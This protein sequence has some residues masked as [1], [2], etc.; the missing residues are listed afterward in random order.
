[1]PSSARSIIAMFSLNRFLDVKKEDQSLLYF[2]YYAFLCSGMMTTVLGAILPS[3]S[4]EYGLS[5][6]L[7]G[8]LLSF[9]QIGN[10]IAVYIAG[11]LP[12]AIGRKMST[13]LGASGII[14]GLVFMTLYG[15][16]FFLI[17]AFLLTGIGRGTMSNMT[18]VVVGQSAGNKAGGLNLLHACFAVG[19]FASPLI[20]IAAGDSMWKIPCWIIS[21]L[22]LIALI[23][24][25][26][27]RLSSERSRREKGGETRF[28]K[29]IGFWLNTM[30]MFFYL[31][32]EASLTGWLVTYFIDSGIFPQSIATSMQSILWIMILIGRLVCASISNRM[33]KSVLI[34]IL[35]IIM[36]AFF[37]VMVNASVP[38]LAVI[39]V[40]GV[41]VSMSGIYPTTLSTMPA[42]YNSS[43]VATGTCI[44]VATVGAILMPLVIGTVAESA[45]IASGITLIA[46]ALICMLALM[47]VKLVLTLKGRDLS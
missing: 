30:I 10:L 41:G 1:M 35:G 44:A 18:N 38:A 36:T 3:L 21:G 23:L 14:L 5:Y 47:T 8:S 16:P 46:L 26:T 34:L 9:H 19:A 40:F 29:S 24:L 22:M 43:T 32:A 17:F 6:T 42:D 28:L 31:C 15:N 25:G 27:S 37:S 4:E 33:N 11:F 12:Y 45:G 20:A 39:G 7:Q 2:T 13:L